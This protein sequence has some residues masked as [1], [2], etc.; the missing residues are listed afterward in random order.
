MTKRLAT[1]KLLLLITLVLLAVSIIL[2]VVSLLPENLSGDPPASVL[3]DTTFRLN[4]NETY[5]QGLGSFRGGENITLI[6]QSPSP[7]AKN[8]SV[9]FP[10]PSNTIITYSDVCYSNC[11]SENMTYSFIATPNYYDAVFTSNSTTSGLIHFQV[12]VQQPEPSFPFSWLTEPAKIM[13]L[14]S[15]GASIV[16]ML[17]P[18]FAAFSLPHVSTLH[19]PALSKKNRRY[20]L[21]TLLLSLLVWVILLAFN[22][23]SLA[24]LGNW[25]TD[26][27]RDSYVSSLFLKVGFSIFSQPL[28]K[29][30]NFDNSNYIFVTWPQM[31]N[32]YPLG[33]VLVF[34]PFGLLLQMGF[35]PALVYKIQVGLFLFFAT[36]CLYFFLQ[37][38]LKKEMHIGLKLVGIFIIYY[39]LVIYAAN[40]MFDSVAF[41]FSVFAVSMFLVERYDYFFLLIAV[42]AFFKYQ[43]AIFL[44][45]LVILGVLMLL[46][47]NRLKVLI[48]N[49]AVIGG[50]VFGVAS[51]FTAFL[52]APY[53]FSASSQLF[54]NGINAFAPNTQIV[55]SVQSFSVLLTLAFTL[56]YAF[57]MFNKNRLLSLSALFLLFPSF[58]LPYFQNWYF[59]F[60]F[61]YALIPQRKNE[62][63]ATMLW[64]IFMVVVL[65]FAGTNYQPITQLFVHAPQYLR[66]F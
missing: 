27:A 1:A 12:L 41:L 49:K 8:F 17:K 54:M 62:L 19:L 51:L 13:F 47:T 40:G 20:L 59:P 10:A 52:S 11:S 29:L 15:L 4:P 61:L 26:N 38:F 3:L 39:T 6:V 7:F 31:P 63:E 5:R 45:P 35:N 53:L 33:S 24:T 58:T 60:L 16:I 43:A 66:G 14:A 28:A 9:M 50:L 36:L 21:L 18:V 56:A 42:S 46:K 55:W 57:Y 25:Y 34:L 32:L 44:F 48:R 64:L 2:G 22:T 23:N 37:I 30:A 65:A